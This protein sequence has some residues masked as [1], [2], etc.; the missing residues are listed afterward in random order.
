MCEISSK[1]TIRTPEWRQGFV[2]GSLLLILNVFYTLFWRLSLFTLRKWRKPFC[3][4]KILPIWLL[5]SYHVTC[6]FQSE[7]TLYICL[8]VKECLARNR[9]DIWSL[10][11]WV[12]LQSLNP[13]NI[14]ENKVGCLG[15]DVNFLFWEKRSKCFSNNGTETH[16]KI[17]TSWKYYIYVMC[18]STLKFGNKSLLHELKCIYIQRFW[19]RSNHQFC[20]FSPFCENILSKD[21]FWS[22]ILSQKP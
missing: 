21:S 2:L 10:S 16:K 6:A 4:R 18:D 19:S 11:D 5:C 1:L 20:V 9:R 14:F 22:F 7:S 15:I 3:L 17:M 8:N 13:A 12:Q